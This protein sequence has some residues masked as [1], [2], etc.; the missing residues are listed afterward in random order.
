MFFRRSSVASWLDTSGHGVSPTPLWEKWLSECT[1]KLRCYLAGLQALWRFTYLKGSCNVCCTTK[2]RKSGLPKRDGKENCRDTLLHV[3]AWPLNILQIHLPSFHTAS[4]VE[5]QGISP[6]TSSSKQY[7]LAS[8]AHR[9]KG[10]FTSAVEPRYKRRWF[11]KPLG[12][13][14]T[15]HSGRCL[16]R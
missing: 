11:N 16:A 9:Y 12:M 4:L 3:L 7:L 5:V 1:G 14:D 15:I 8:K 10:K 6:A 13:T 2:K